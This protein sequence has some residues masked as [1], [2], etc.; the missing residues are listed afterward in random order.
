MT[1]LQF[2][3]E[4]EGGA[5]DCMDQSL[6]ALR[7]LRRLIM[8]YDSP[9]R[10]N[11]IQELWNTLTVHFGRM[12]T[13][14]SDPDQPLELQAGP[15]YLIEKHL[16]QIAKLHLNMSKIHPAAFA[17]LPG[18][19]DLVHSYWRLVTQFGQ[20]YGK[21]TSLTTKIGSDGDA[22]EEDEAP[23]QEKVSLIGLLL[24]RACSKM[25]FNPA[26]TFKYQ[27]V[28]DKEEKNKTRAMVKDQL[29]TPEFARQIMETLVTRFFIFTPRDLK[30]WEEEPDE[31]EKSQEDAGDD[32]EFS[33]RTCSEKLFLDLVINYKDVLVPQLLNIISTASSRLL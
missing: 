7:V 29:L 9:H 15:K 20:S 30:Q 18:S 6:L 1:F 27:Q 14:I 4:D 16:L 33:I 2:G 24:L 26:Q 31:W 3:G 23:F 10:Q 17:L 19:L 11:A 12:L 28:E 21:P 13:I 25:I 8:V 5:L 22:D 32:W